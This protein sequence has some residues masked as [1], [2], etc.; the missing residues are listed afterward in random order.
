MPLATAC[1]T[2]QQVPI[3]LAPLTEGGN[4]APIDG[5]PTIT[6]LSGDATF[7]QDPAEPLVFRVVSGPGAGTSEFRVDADA[8]LDGDVRTISDTVTLTVTSAEAATL[9]L[10][11]GAPEPKP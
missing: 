7:S 10:S 2:E 11:A 9:G 5:L 4:P 8:D 6:V 3:T 1:T